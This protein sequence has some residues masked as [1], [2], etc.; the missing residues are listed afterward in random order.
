MKALLKQIKDIA[1]VIREILKI[2][3]QIWLLCRRFPV[4]FGSLA[5]FAFIYFGLRWYVFEYPKLTI[6]TYFSAIGSHSFPVAWDAV[7]EDYRSRR[8]Q[9]LDHF[10]GLYA[11]TSAPT[12]IKVAYTD[13][14]LNPFSVLL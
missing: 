13:S 2:F 12:G 5:L 9:T 14:T 8:W 4:I 6:R 11:T 10:A 7:A 3:V 1:E